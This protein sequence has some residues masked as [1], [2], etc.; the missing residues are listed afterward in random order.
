MT[1]EVLNTQPTVINSEQA[2]DVTVWDKVIG[3]GKRVLLA[4]GLVIAPLLAVE[5]TTELP[6]AADEYCG[7]NGVV[8]GTTPAGEPACVPTKYLDPPPTEAPA[9]RPTAPPTTRAPRVT[10]P[11]TTR[12]RAVVATTTPPTTVAATTTTEATTTT[13]LAPTT[14]TTAEV[15][16]TTITASTVG[17]ASGGNSNGGVIGKSTGAESHDSNLPLGIAAAG[18]IAGLGTWAVRR[19]KTHNDGNGRHQPRHRGP[20]IKAA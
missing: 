1:Q 4:A 12:A 8:Q 7:P 18:T 15:T 11:P 10:A 13:T 3:C 20:K 17:D 14:T 5:I 16:T 2:P 19:R 6:A 9:P